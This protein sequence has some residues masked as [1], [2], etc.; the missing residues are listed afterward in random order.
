MVFLIYAAAEGFL[1]T[2]VFTVN[3]VY[4]VQVARLSPLQLVLV[5]TALETTAFLFE[6]PTGVVADLYSRRVSVIVGVF[7]T[8]LSFLIQGTWPVFL[9]IILSQVVWGIGYTF[10]SGALQAWISDEV[11]E[12]RAAGLF[13]RSAR[14]G[15]TG[16]LLATGLSVLLAQRTLNLPILAGGALFLLLGL[17]LLACMTEEGWRPANQAERSNFQHM[18]A[19]LRS[20]MRMVKRR[21]A[22]LSIFGIGLFFGLYSEGFDRLWTAHLLEQFTFPA[23]GNLLQVTWFGLLSAA[24][25]LISA[26]ALAIVQHNRL[27]EQRRLVAAQAAL[28]ALLLGGLVF[29][30]LARQFWLAVAM[31]V[32]ISVVRSVISPLYTAWVNHRLDPAVRATVLSASGQVDALGQIAGG[33]LVGVIAQSGGIPLGLLSSAA[34]L[35]PVAML[36][37]GQ[38]RSRTSEPESEQYPSD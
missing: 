13:L 4:F 36:F 9:P 23:L 38:I 5:G 28:T 32:L 17:F 7:L 24:S 25:M 22:L 33:P 30:A 34:L 15:L 20:A 2:L 6:I 3:M 12:E 37:A 21:P 31:Y 14:F 19:T 26:A 35:A 11:G 1:F 16:A 8:G 10:T 18:A 29:F 27:H